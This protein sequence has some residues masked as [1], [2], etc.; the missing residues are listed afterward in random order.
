MEIVLR[1]QKLITN[2][3]SSMCRKKGD[4]LFYEEGV[5]DRGA[6]LPTA[7]GKIRAELPQMADGCKLY[8]FDKYF[9]RVK[10]KHAEYYA[11]AFHAWSETMKLSEIE[12]VTVLQDNCFERIL[13]DLFQK[14]ISIRYDPIIS[15]IHDRF[16]LFKNGEKYIGLFVGT[17]LNGLGK[18]ICITSKLSDDDCSELVKSLFHRTEQQTES[19]ECYVDS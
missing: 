5:I 7:L 6:A 3:I 16:W 9:T 15:K 1:Q 4:N 12:I 17:S 10:C 8:I 2:I 13:C 14:G 19:T 11:R 18:Q